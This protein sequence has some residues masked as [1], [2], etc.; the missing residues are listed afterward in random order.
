MYTLL[1]LLYSQALNKKYYTCYVNSD[2]IGGW[3]EVYDSSGQG[4]MFNLMFEMDCDA[5]KVGTCRT[6]DFDLRSENG[7][8]VEAYSF[9][10]NADIS[11]THWISEYIDHSIFDMDPFGPVAGGIYTYCITSKVDGML[12]HDKCGT[13]RSLEDSSPPVLT[14]ATSPPAVVAPGTVVTFVL[15][16]SDDAVLNYL[17]VTVNGSFYERIGLKTVNN[18]V[19]TSPRSEYVSYE[20]PS[21]G[22]IQ[23]YDFN[24]LACDLTSKCTSVSSTVIVAKD[25]GGGGG[26]GGGSTCSDTGCATV[27]CQ[28]KALCQATSG[29]TWS[30]PDKSC[31]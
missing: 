14:I 1:A 18:K 7:T 17:T 12:E 4:A 3:T 27:D 22:K 2:S 26:G 5:C 23:P 11:Y 19:S 9:T 16:V 8:I 20:I 15:D 6:F 10:D 31:S 21:K 24:F 30:N 13:L 25:G 28:D 29:C